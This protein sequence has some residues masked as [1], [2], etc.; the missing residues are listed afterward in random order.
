MK[1]H[2]RPFTHLYPYAVRYFIVL[3]QTPGETEVGVAGSGIGNFDLLE[4]T[5]DQMI[6]E[7]VLLVRGHGHRQSLVA[8]PQVGR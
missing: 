4:P 2:E 3:N 8:I 7:K 1:E 6:K 5:L